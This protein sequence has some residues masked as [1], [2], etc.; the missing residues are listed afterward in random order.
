VV[1]K[2]DDAT[3]GSTREELLALPAAVDLDPANRAPSFSRTTV[4]RSPG[5]ADIRGTAVVHTR[6]GNFPGTSAA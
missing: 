4:T 3:R 1:A 6:P 2:R 5:V